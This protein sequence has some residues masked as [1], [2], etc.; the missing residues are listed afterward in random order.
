MYYTEHKLKKGLGT[1]LAKEN[2]EE[3]Q[4]KCCLLVVGNSHACQATLVA[5]ID[6]SMQVI[7]LILNA[8]RIVS[9]LW[10]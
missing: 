4:L 7:P 9:E 1:G 3:F 10:L 5:L 8:L 6:A 2:I